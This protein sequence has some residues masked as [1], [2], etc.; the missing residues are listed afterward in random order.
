MTE[1]E[2]RN[3]KIAL[4]ERLNGHLVEMRPGFDDSITGFN[5]AW[6]VMGKFFDDRIAKAKRG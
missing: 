6:D 4:S 1:V 3:L 2:L 5:E